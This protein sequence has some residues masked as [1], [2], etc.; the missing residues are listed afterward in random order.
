MNQEKQSLAQDKEL[1]KKS[2]TYNRKVVMATNVAES[3][4][5]IDGLRYVIDTGYELSGT[6]D[7]ENHARKLERELITQAQA[8]QRMGRAGRTEPGICYHLYSKDTFENRME[9]FP[10]P[11]IQTSDITTECLKLISNDKINTTDKLTQ[12]LSNFIEPPKELYLRSA[13]DT[14]MQLGAIENNVITKLGQLINN[15]PAD[16]IFASLAII[17]G[18]IYNCGFEVMKILSLIEV[19]KGNISDLYNL[20][21]TIVGKK[22]MNEDQLKQMTQ[23]LEKEI[24]RQ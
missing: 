23:M 9:K 24:Q 7:A 19:S 4:L 2:N 17:Y 22:G 10:K 6:Y 20:P 14:L 3:S 13:I 12:T 18:K 16:N 11:D 15:I 5:T 21:S 8:K 1:Y